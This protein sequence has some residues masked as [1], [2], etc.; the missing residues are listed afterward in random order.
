MARPLRIVYEGAIYHIM[1]RGHSRSVLF[2]DEHDWRPVP[3]VTRFKA[4]SIASVLGHEEVWDAIESGR[5]QE[6]LLEQIYGTV[7]RS[8]YSRSQ[9]GR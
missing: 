8:R 7:D 3:E 5:S 2:Q 1:V 6:M 9:F 4:G